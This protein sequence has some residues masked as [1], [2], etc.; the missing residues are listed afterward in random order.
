LKKISRIEIPIL[1]SLLEDGAT[2]I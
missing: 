1:F 2:S